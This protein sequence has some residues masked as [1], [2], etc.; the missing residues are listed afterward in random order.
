MSDVTPV[1]RNWQFLVWRQHITIVN[2]LE[3]TDE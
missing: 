2:P 1:Y 3:Q